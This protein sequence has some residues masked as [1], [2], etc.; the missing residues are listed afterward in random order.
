VT[1]EI[2]LTKLGYEKLMNFAV[3]TSL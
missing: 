1:E 3:G 2:N